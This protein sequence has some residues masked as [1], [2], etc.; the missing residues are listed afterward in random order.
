MKADLEEAQRSAAAAVHRA[1]TEAESAERQRAAAEELSSELHR[2]LVRA[3]SEL[4]G[5]SY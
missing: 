4:L 3:L 2:L 1:D 5:F